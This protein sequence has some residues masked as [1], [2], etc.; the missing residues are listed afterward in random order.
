MMPMPDL[1]Q[2]SKPFLFMAELSLDIKKPGLGQAFQKG[3]DIQAL[4]PCLMRAQRLGV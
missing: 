3:Q 4:C 1:S 2:V